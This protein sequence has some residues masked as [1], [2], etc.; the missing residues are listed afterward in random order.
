[1]F[2]SQLWLETRCTELITLL[3]VSYGILVLFDEELNI[4]SYLDVGFI[5]REIVAI[6]SLRALD[7]EENR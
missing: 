7:T 1:M 4:F 3:Q 5:K 6:L 2:L